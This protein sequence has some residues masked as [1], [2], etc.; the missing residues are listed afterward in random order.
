VAFANVFGNVSPRAPLIAI[1]A[2]VDAA[3]GFSL[4]VYTRDALSST[5]QHCTT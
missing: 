2:I 4:P 1:E 5:D 3:K